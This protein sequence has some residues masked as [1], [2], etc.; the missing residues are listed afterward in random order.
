[1]DKKKLFLLAGALIVAIGTALLARS[2]FAGAAAPEASAAAEV[3]PTGPRVLV[4]KRGLPVGTIVTADAVS[5]QL[6]PKELVQDAYF[7][8]GEADMQALLGTVVRHPMTAGEPVTQGTLVAPGDR[9]FLAAALGPGM[10][11]VTVPVSA[12]TGVAGFVFPGDRVDMVLTQSVTGGDGDALRTSET[13]LTNLRVLA[14]DQSTETTT[15]EDGR[16]VVR[17]FRTVTMEVT[18]RIA[19]KIA[20]A[21]TIGTLS[22]SL[23]SIADNQS[24]LERA[25]ASGDVELPNDA[26]PEE[27]ERLLRAAMSRPGEGAT[28]FQTGGDVSRFQRRTVPPR[29]EGNTNRPTGPEQQGAPQMTPGVTANTAPTGPTVRVT[30]GKSTVV[31]PVGRG[32]GAL[33]DRQSGA[34][35]EGARVGSLGMST[36]R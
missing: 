18:P 24:E 19:E 29:R 13:I 22:L 11:A 7:I 2:M 3:E 32:A 30:R 10:R 25:I 36:L 23:R 28:T 21:Q 31:T 14:T 12:R 27:E 20:V 9:G 4:A 1:M 35:G 33:L 17:A 34:M 15:S 8:D 16:T 26:S 6:W 5:Y